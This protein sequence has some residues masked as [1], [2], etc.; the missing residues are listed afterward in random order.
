SNAGIFLATDATVKVEEAS[1]KWLVT[2]EN[3]RYVL[4]KDGSTVF[5]YNRKGFAVDENLR[6]EHVYYYCLFPFK[7]DPLEYIADPSHRIAAT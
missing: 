7:K 6:S 4:K 1:K 2:Y 5:A 3:T